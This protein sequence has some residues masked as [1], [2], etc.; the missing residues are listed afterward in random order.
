MK[1][2]VQQTNRSVRT[3]LWRNA[4]LFLLGYILVGHTQTYAQTKYEAESAT[5]T[6]MS[7]STGAGGYTG[8]GYATGMDADGDKVIFTV[9]VASAGS[10]PLVIRFRNSCAPCE[11]YQNVKV[12]TGAAVYTQFT[13]TGSG[14]QDKAYGNVSLN[15]GNNT[16]EISKS[17]GFTDIDYITVG[18]TTTTTY[19]LNVAATN[20]SITRSPNKT[21]YTSGETVTLTAAA[22][23]GYT[24]SGWSG[25]AS[26][27][28]N[29]LTVT[30]NSNKNITANFTATSTSTKYEAE[31]AMLTGMSV[32]TGAGGYTGSGYADGMDASGDKIVF[33]VNAASAGSYPLVIRF[34]N[35]CAPCEKYQNV[36]VN[37]AAAV[38]TQFANTG[39]GWEDKGYGNVSLNAGN[40]TIEISHSW[41]YTAIDY[42][43]VGVAG[44]GE[45][46][47][48]SPGTETRPSYNTST[49]FF[50]KN[51][52]IY[53]AN[54]K[55]FIPIGVNGPTFWQDETCGKNSIDDIARAGFNAVRITSVTPTVNGWSWSSR[56]EN[57]RA[58]VASC[59]ANKLVPM[60]EMHDATCG[61]KYEN[62]P[63][64]AKYNLKP[65]VD[66]W[67]TPGMVQLCK[68]YEKQLIVNVANEWG[69][70]DYPI[71]WKEGCKTA[72]SRMRAAGIKNMLVIDAG[73]SCGQYPNL[74]IQYAQE[75]LNSDPERN[76][77]FSIHMY[78]GW[79][80]GNTNVTNWRFQVEAKLQE[81]KD[82][83]IPMM[84]G[85]FGWEGT[86]DVPY[87][88]RVVMSKT[89]ELG[90]GWFFWAWF[91]QPNY[92]YYNVVKDQCIG[93]NSNSDLTAAGNGVVNGANGSKARAKMASIYASARVATPE[94]DY[95][96]LS[97]N[98]STNGLVRVQ[99]SGFDANART[100]VSVM[101][102]G[103]RAVY[104]E[105]VQT[106]ESGR[107]VVELNTSKYQ[108]GLY[109]VQVQQGVRRIV[110]K[111]LVQ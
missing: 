32:S 12:N 63:Q 52:K 111:L 24:F 95:V 69:G 89:A 48:P 108:G 7:V 2:S 53:D 75:I 58:L 72:I 27:S 91:D 8:T 97:P 1:T 10:Y 103:G 13:N 71:D 110:R 14:W 62:D 93:Y 87:D 4:W 16:I 3:S 50:M 25:D 74:V 45:N 40:N 83:G 49:G 109:L 55:E 81:F 106:D 59:V 35:S 100:N 60:L 104:Q 76:V 86:S 101:D 36:K 96:V 22:N 105:L 61:W 9:N 19:T 43:T 85:E 65:V 11:K 94:Q 26:G 56:I 57:Q 102:I 31:S 44:G 64:G 21:A 46:P 33:T 99:I 28:T 15:T 51:A 47:N 6:G 30:M 20:G 90:M 17:W 78:A 92:T 29:P 107:K 37:S 98:P 54:G 79:Y 39:S 67:V 73:G 80:S 66:Y 42:I 5:L 82:K 41:G 23:S 70:T 68:D 34:R 88:P 84:V 18:T 77:V 38:Y